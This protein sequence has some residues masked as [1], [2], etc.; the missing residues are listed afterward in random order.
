MSDASPSP[1]PID[2]SSEI[3]KPAALATDPSAPPQL[4]GGDQA[5][6][7]ALPAGAPPDVP[8]GAVVPPPAIQESTPAPAGLDVSTLPLVDSPEAARA[9]L[10]DAAGIPDVIPATGEPGGP[11]HPYDTIQRIRTKLSAYGEECLRTIQPEI[12]YLLELTNP[13]HDEPEA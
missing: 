9:A 7:Q 10:G 11:E 8:P 2:K 13:A 4:S 3:S 1:A 12:E 6:T 5:G